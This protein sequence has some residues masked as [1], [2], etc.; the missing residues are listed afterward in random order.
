MACGAACIR[1]SVMKF[2]VVLASHGFDTG[3]NRAL[4]CFP[5]RRNIER[6]L[7]LHLAGR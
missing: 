7:E 1:D 3:R 5:N 6:G 2:P 4:P